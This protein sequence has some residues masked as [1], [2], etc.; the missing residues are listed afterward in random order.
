MITERAEV[1]FPRFSHILPNKGVVP[2][3]CRKIE[4]IQ[5]RSENE[6]YLELYYLFRPRRRAIIY[7][8][9]TVRR[10]GI[11]MWRTVLRHLT[12]IYIS[13]YPPPNIRNSFCL[14]VKMFG[15]GPKGLWLYS[16]SIVVT[17]G[18]RTRNNNF[19]SL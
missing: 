3:L 13:R 18:Q 4:N 16:A 1:V 6:E 10:K 8:K 5:Q 17:R 14:V 9:I 7:D 11:N 12:L 2:H 15:S 19:Q